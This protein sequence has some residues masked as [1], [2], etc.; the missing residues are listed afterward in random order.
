M[1]PRNTKKISAALREHIRLPHGAR[2]EDMG[3]FELSGKAGATH[4]YAVHGAQPN[5][6]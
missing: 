4:V 5:L 1:S 6:Q 2:A 3:A